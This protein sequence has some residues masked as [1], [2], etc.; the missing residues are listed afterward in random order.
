MKMRRW[1]SLPPTDEQHYTNWCVLIV[2][3]DFSCLFIT[4]QK[5]KKRSNQDAYAALYVTFVLDN[6]ICG[7]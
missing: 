5:I 6:E 4:V 2:Y 7:I 3:N 1:S